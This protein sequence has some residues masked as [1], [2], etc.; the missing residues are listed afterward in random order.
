MSL[1]CN[2][3]GITIKGLTFDYQQHEGKI[4]R[5]VGA[6]N[7]SIESCEFQNLGNH[8]SQQSV[9]MIFITK[10]SSNIHIEKCR[11]IHCYSSSESS[12]A[13]VWINFSN[14]EERCHHIFIDRCYFDDFQPSSDADAIKILGQNEDVFAYITN[15][16]FYRCDKRALKFQARECHSKNNRIYCTRPMYCAI[17]FQR[18]NGSS[19]NDRI[20]I[21][22]DG[23]SFINPNSGLLYRAVC[24]AQGNVSIKGLKVIA[25]NSIDNSH[26]IAI[27]LQSFGGYDDGSVKNVILD[28]CRFD[29]QHSFITATDAIMNISNVKLKRLSYKNNRLSNSTINIS[30]QCKATLKQ[31]IK[32]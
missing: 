3:D 12:S 14:S 13:G 18:G 6:R 8:S 25:E 11:F 32:I 24:L 31:H 26:Q 2:S 5:I 29:G 28:K 22:Y 7:I 16:E 19:I 4:M 1:Y 10:G 20:I 17:D 21:D 27:C 15:C 23:Q 30:S 9:G